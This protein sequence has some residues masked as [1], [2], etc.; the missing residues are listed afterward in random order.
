MKKISVK[1]IY[2][3]YAATTPVAPEV[4]KAMRPYWS[5]CFG[6]PGSLHSF[7]QEAMAAIDLSRER[8]SKMIGAQFREVIFTGSATEANN[9]AIR[10][11]LRA[12]QKRHEGIPRLIVSSVEHE[13]VLETARLLES[14]GVDVAYLS[15]S[16]EG[17]INMKEL[18]SALNDQ[19][20]LVSIMYGN[21]EIGTVQPIQKISRV[22]SDFRKQH[23]A[24]YPLF[25][26]DAVQA[27]P[28]I[29]VRVD[30]LGVDLATF[31]G[32]KVYGPKGVGALYVRGLTERSVIEPLLAGGGQEFGF[33]SGT[34]NVSLI[35]GF[36]RAVELRGQKRKKEE[37]KITALK[38]YCFQKM[39]L[40]DKKILLNGVSLKEGLPHILNVAFSSILA[41]D[42]LV[43]LDLHGVAISAGSA[44]T[45]RSPEPSHVLKALGLPTDRISRSVRF[46]FGSDTTRAQID[47]AIRLIKKR[48][49][50]KGR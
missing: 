49:L 35:V 4:E 38:K 9:L 40:V 23:N 42:L 8:F 43:Y 13:S 50:E 32:H 26:T 21:N 36:V 30:D 25:H 20:V 44:C 37:E 17:Y 39:S 10:G 48:F 47:T 46:S 14:E 19:T 6:N 24:A 18:E 27:L 16:K 12:W 33:R 1:K 5:G 29:V 34:E 2:L 15:V 22:I 7:G 11:V 41:S 45:A 3:D 28:Y 31:S